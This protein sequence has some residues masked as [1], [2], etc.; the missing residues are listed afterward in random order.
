[1]SALAITQPRIQRTAT[2]PHRHSAARSIFPKGVDSC[3]HGSQRPRVNTA[4]DPYTITP[5]WIRVCCRGRPPCLPS[6]RPTPAFEEPADLPPHSQRVL[7]PGSN[8]GECVRDSRTSS[9]A[10]RFPC[11]PTILARRCRLPGAASFHSPPARRPSSRHSGGSHTS[12]AARKAPR[13]ARPS[14]TQTSFTKSRLPSIRRS[15]TP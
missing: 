9:I 1:M 14:W 10:W 13:V 12:R 7:K 6:S 3:P 8:T 15:T 5:I 2:F 4:V 11:S